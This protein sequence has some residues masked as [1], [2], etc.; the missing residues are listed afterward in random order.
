MTFFSMH[1]KGPL[2][3]FQGP[4]IDGE[5]QGLPIPTPSLLTGMIGAALGLSRG[6][7][8][9]LQALQDSLSLA[10]VVHNPGVEIIDY[11]I[12]DLSK[13][14]MR[15][16]MWASGTQV[17]TREGSGIEGLRQ[18]W[19]PY[20]A[21]VDITSVVELQEHAPFGAPEILAA[22]REPARPLFLGRTSCPPE[23]EIAGEIIDAS[24]LEDAAQQ[25]AGARKS[26]LIY[27]PAD[28]TEP[29]WGDLPFS[30][31]G[32]RDWRANRHSGGQLY[33]CRRPADRR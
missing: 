31:P 25:L 19:R 30:I 26:S 23:R 29:Q 20:L 1:L 10:C 9:K 32:R 12:A 17:V 28:R 8:E 21:D 33:L 27:V 15:G 18:Q 13:P 5:P 22:L 4:K 16:P 7:T 2:V 11:Q 6:S 3:A 14:H 24:S